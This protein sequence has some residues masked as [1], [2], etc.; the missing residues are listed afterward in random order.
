MDQLLRNSMYA[1]GIC[2]VLAGRKSICT[3]TL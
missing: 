3:F 1:V 2:L